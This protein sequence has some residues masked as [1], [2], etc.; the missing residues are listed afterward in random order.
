[1]AR[2][3]VG[4]GGTATEFPATDVRFDDEPEPCVQIRDMIPARTMS[5][6]RIDYR[7]R[8]LDGETELATAT[9]TIY[10]IGE[11]GAADGGAADGG[12]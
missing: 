4:D 8:V 2:S 10:A 3:L 9:R 5:E 12:S 1:M 6:G 7:V 11:A